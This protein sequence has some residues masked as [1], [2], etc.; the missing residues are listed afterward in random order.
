LHPMFEEFCRAG[1][2]QHHVLRRM[3]RR[4]RDE[5][6]PM[7]DEREVLIEE[8]ASLREQVAALMREPKRGKKDKA[9]AVTV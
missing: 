5:I 6:Q 7:L 3:Q 1:A 9:E 8:N 2:L 4:V